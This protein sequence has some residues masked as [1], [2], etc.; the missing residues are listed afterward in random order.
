MVSHARTIRDLQVRCQKLAY[1]CAKLQRQLDENK[2]NA[3]LFF[4]IGAIFACFTL[5]CI[6]TFNN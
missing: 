3:P 1:Q 6:I 5:G 4:A 2:F